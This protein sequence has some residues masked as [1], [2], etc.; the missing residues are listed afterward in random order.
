MFASNLKMEE[1]KN[2]NDLCEHCGENHENY[3]NLQHFV[4]QNQ[5]FMTGLFKEIRYVTIILRSHNGNYIMAKRI[6]PL[7]GNFNKWATPGGRREKTVKRLQGSHTLRLKF[8]N[9]EEA[10][11][12]EL[13]EETNITLLEYQSFSERQWTFQYTGE[14]E[15][16]ETIRTTTVKEL[17]LKSN[18]IPKLT[19]PENM[20][21]WREFT[22]YEAL[23]VPLIDD[24]RNYFRMKVRDIVHSRKI[25][26]IILE[27]PVGVGKSFIAK[28]LLQKL[29]H[30]WCLRPEVALKCKDSIAK[31]YRKEITAL[32]LEIEIEKKYFQELVEMFNQKKNYF[33][34]ERTQES[35]Y[36][37]SRIA[38]IP[39]EQIE[40]QQK[41]NRSIYQELFYNAQV[42]KI[43]APW[44][45]VQD[46]ILKRNRQIETNATGKIDLDQ[47]KNIYDQYYIELKKIYK[48]VI[49]HSIK[50]YSEGQGIFEWYWSNNKYLNDLEINKLVEKLERNWKDYI[51]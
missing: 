51:Q 8:E 46:Q 50:N 48:G 39:E 26:M 9:I 43:K 35:T 10:S 23:T 5:Q 12:R 6:N 13:Y 1:S 11:R 14:Y 44:K 31:F 21:E 33:I 30:E 17:I 7:K 27:G 47:M 18:Q 45:Q 25:R 40:R 37:F 41:Y 24:L 19:E 3:Q 2:Q 49:Q 16:E 34:Y 42:V 29:G 28:K 15:G 20:T 32:E 38:K 22:P 36:I 4:N